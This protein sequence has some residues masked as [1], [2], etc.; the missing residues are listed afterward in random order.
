MWTKDLSLVLPLKYQLMKMKGLLHQYHVSDPEG[1]SFT[2]ELMPAGTDASLFRYFGTNPSTKNLGF[3]DFNGADYEDPLDENG[4]NVYE[5]QLRAVEDKASGI[6]T[7]LN[8]S[9]NI[10]DLKDTWAISWNNIFK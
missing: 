5:L 3:N 10:N 8:L 9:I 4:D 2:W 1:D 6:E 7:I